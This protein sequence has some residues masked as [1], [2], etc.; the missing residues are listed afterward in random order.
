M[1]SLGHTKLIDTILHITL[2]PNM[3]VGWYD[4]MESLSTVWH[5]NEWIRE[6]TMVHWWLEWWMVVHT[7]VPGCQCIFNSNSIEWIISSPE[8]TN[9]PWSGSNLTRFSP[10]ISQWHWAEVN[11]VI[12]IIH[13]TLKPSWYALITHQATTSNNH[14]DLTMTQMLHDAYF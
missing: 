8:G 6:L 3:V 7:K 2:L 11:M 9:T 4:N 1:A 10:I 5:H 14:T 13:I 12:F